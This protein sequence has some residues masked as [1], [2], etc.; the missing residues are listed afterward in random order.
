MGNSLVVYFSRI[1]ENMVNGNVE[2]IKKGFTEIVAEKIAKY[3]NSNIFELKP[4][5][6]YPYNYEECVKRAKDEYENNSVVI[7]NY[8]LP[9]LDAYDTIYL[10]F[11]NWWRSYPRIVATFLGVYNFIGKTIKPFCTNE[12]GA[13]G[14]GEIEMRNTVKGAIIHTGFACKGHEAETCDIKLQE[15][16]F[17]E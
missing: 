1:G 13:L 12:E 10:G 6:P 3:T 9:N 14:V 17:K 15:W 7:F 11:P 5:E 2:V 4:A 16:L 8:A